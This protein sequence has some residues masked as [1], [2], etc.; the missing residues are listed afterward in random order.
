MQQPE[1]IEV[2]RR[3]LL[4]IAGTLFTRTPL[5]AEGEKI[6]PAMLEAAARAKIKI[7]PLRRNIY[8]L[9]GSGGNIAVLT[10][11]DGKL[12]VDAGFSV[13]RPAIASAL[14][15]INTDPITHLINTH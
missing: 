14:T 15:S 11:K 4:T 2:S 12:L 13:S 1:S 5:F 10:G 8:V 7:H 3:S 9:E 6:V